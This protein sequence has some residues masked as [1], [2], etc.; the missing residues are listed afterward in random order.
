MTAGQSVVP[1]SGKGPLSYEDY[2]DVPDDGQRH[3]LNDGEVFVSPA[4]NPEHQRVTR[5]LAIALQV[6]VEA[7]AGAELFWAPID[8]ILA[9]P[10]RIRVP[11]P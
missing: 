4:P 2:A 6:W 3:E 5:R 11:G 7:H 10:D 9:D 8:L 1:P